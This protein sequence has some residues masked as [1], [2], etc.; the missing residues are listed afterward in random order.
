MDIILLFGIGSQTEAPFF[1]E[2]AKIR[3][4]KDTFRVRAQSKSL[5]DFVWFRRVVRGG[6][7]EKDIK[8]RGVRV[9]VVNF[10]FRQVFPA[11]FAKFVCFFFCFFSKGAVDDGIVVAFL[12]GRD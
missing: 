5:K 4:V 10:E 1:R 6:E 11:I 3:P 12:M 2:E 7:D 9:C 8:L